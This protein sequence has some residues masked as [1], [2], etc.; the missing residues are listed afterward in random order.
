MYKMKLGNM[1]ESNCMVRKSFLGI[2]FKLRFKQGTKIQGSWVKKSIW[3]EG[4]DR[5]K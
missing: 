1:L 3:A 5:N 2:T 4:T